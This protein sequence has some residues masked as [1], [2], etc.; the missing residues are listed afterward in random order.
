MTSNDLQ[1]NPAFQN[2]SPE[3]LQFLTNFM[4]QEKSGNARDMMNLL[5]AFSGTA[6]KTGHSVYRR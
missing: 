1:N 2:L 4:G 5:M 6:K 3:K